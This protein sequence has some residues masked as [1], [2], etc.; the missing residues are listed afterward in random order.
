[1][2][3]W[4]KWREESSNMKPELSR[5]N[6]REPELL[7]AAISGRKYKTTPDN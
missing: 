5:A 7:N 4:N 2:G 3:D 6:C 1:M